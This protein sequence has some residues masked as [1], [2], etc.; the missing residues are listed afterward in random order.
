MLEKLN[1]LTNWQ[2][3]II[4]A[5]IGFAVFSSG[6]RNPFLGDDL[7][8]IVSNPVV[9]SL[10]HVKLIFEGG[11]FFNGNTSMPLTGNYYRPLMMIAFAILYTVFGAHSIY[12]HVFQMATVIGSAFLLFLIFRRW[13]N[14]LLA[15]SM[16]LVF[17]VHPINSEM[18]FFIPTTQDSLFLR[19]N[20]IKGVALAVICLVLSLLSKETGSL[21]VVLAGL[22]LL[23][24]NRKRLLL[25]IY[26]VLPPLILYFII[27]T[28]AVGL[29]NQSA[30]API[31][32]LSLSHRLL[33]DPSIILFY[34]SKLIFPWRLASGYYWVDSRYSLTGVLIPALIDVAVAI[35][36]TAFTLAI[37]QRTSNS[38]FRTYLFFLIWMCVGLLPS[39][40]LIP[41][42]MTVSEAWF[43]FSTAGF[44]GMV[45]VALVAFQPK[46]RSSWFGATIVIILV[47]L[48]TRTF[49]R[50]SDYRS[51]YILAR[52]DVV[53]SKDDYVA[54]ENVSSG[55]YQSGNL[56]EA[57][58][59]AVKS[60]NTFP[61][62]TNYT[63]LGL[64]LAKQGEYKDAV[65]SYNNALSYGD[66]SYI[67]DDEAKLTLVFGTYQQ[68][69]DFL[70]Q[71]I[72]EYPQDYNLWFY[73]ALL[74]YR[75]GYYT[76]AHDDVIIANKY[77][78]V[79]SAILNDIQNRLTF[80][81]DEPDIAAHVKIPQ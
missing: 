38:N 35:A 24:F 74:E 48:G 50:G 81:V 45:C 59:Y 75:N 79:P 3:A 68:D 13:F 37:R 56:V 33:T 69:E 41:L 60:I 71:A 1:K 61:T 14:A 8:Q 27:R 23:F 57:A 32:K 26:L 70:S 77:G 62:F 36:I 63:H 66:Y 21:F 51:Y 6:L 19:L 9:H 12:F 28:H 64:I 39:L 17:L 5:I 2:V 29:N 67:N 15:L 22:Y 7:T 31:D 49:I 4:L 34:L 25:Y 78:Q 40:Q 10:G 18:A 43:Y 58:S 52:H 80:I 42:D 72:A 47:L 44:L 20:S 46:I 30:V 11:T 54:L 55:L 65:L 53:A 76:N 73:R 16:S